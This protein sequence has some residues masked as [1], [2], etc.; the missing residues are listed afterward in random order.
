M[1]GVEI[2]PNFSFAFCVF[3][4][5]VAYSE[6]EF[7]RGARDSVGE[8]TICLWQRNAAVVRTTLERREREEEGEG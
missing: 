3:L 4:W 5:A 7:E 1:W 8:T 6:E 2:T